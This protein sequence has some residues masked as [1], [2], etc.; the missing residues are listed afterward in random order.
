[1]LVNEADLKASHRPVDLIAA[2]LELLLDPLLKEV[3]AQLEA[4]V[5]LLQIIEVL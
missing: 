1:M 3:D 5:L 4:E 2:V